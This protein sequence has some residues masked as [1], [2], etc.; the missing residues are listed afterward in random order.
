MEKVYDNVCMVCK[1]TDDEVGTFK[2]GIE[3]I[4][5][6]ETV[7]L[8]SMKTQKKVYERGKQSECQF[9]DKCYFTKK[10][11]KHFRRSY[12]IFRN[13]TKMFNILTIIITSAM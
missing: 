4:K 3:G 9:Q 8:K 10:P 2:K 5:I 6:L 1:C 7:H 13:V 11:K 12:L